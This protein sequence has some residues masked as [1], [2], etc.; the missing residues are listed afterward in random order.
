VSVAAARP[1]ESAAPATAAG[2]LCILV[3]DESAAVR[4]RLREL[5]ES[6]EHQVLVAG[7]GAEAL[8][9]LRA[10]EPDIVLM[11]ARMPSVNGIELTERLRASAVDR[12]I[13]VI[14]L[15]D[16]GGEDDVVRGLGSGAD[17]YLR[18]PVDGSLLKARI[19]SF[20]RM[21]GMQRQ[22]REQAATLAQFRDAQLSEHELA[23]VLIGNIV[24]RES[25]ADPALAWEV[26]PSELF[27]GDVV[28]AA[29]AP[30]GVLYTMLGD[31]TG[32]GLTASVSLIP[33]LQVFY[34]MVRK[35]RP[36]EEMAR[37]INGHLKELL[38]LGRY[39]AATL[40]RVDERVH[41]AEVWNGGMPPAFLLDVR[42]DTRNA[43]ASTHLP[44]GIAPVDEFDATCT[45]FEWD[46]PGQIVF[47]SDGVPEAEDRHGRPF[48]VGRLEAALRAS[49]AELRAARVMAALR[50]YLGEKSAIDDASI[51]TVRLP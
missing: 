22:L 6:E 51:L 39:L 38:P 31:A 7:D 12:W 47:Y 26:L 1:E 20:R 19:G 25:L 5:L 37:E 23:G 15:C 18:K 36:L 33:A 34:G 8:A 48:G 50:A 35:A 46:S 3:V 40:M 24:R 21:A 45:P 41:A 32:H 4:A 14:L 27:S 13:P 10:G 49:P 42:G 16:P 29:R 17:D 11:D 9:V 30:N 43:F 28:A 2:G 44:L